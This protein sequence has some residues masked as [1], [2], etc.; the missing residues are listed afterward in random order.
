M[1][2]TAL[3]PLPPMKP[4]EKLRYGAEA[5]AFFAF[6]GLFRILGVDARQRSAAS[7]A[8]TSSIARASP[9]RARRIFAPLIPI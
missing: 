9:T 5:A 8:A 7:S 6:M 2:D 4:L 3:P 1:S